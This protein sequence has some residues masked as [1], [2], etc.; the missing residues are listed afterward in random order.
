MLTTHL[1]QQESY[2][3]RDAASLVSHCTQKA[4]LGDTDN[5]KE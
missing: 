4:R 2:W 5:V 1:L 3:D